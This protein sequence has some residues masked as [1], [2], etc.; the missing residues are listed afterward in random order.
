MF[1][2]CDCHGEFDGAATQP[3]VDGSATVQ[4]VPCHA[5]AADAAVERE[6]VE[7]VFALGGGE[8]ADEP[9][10]PWVAS[11]ATEADI[12][13]SARTGIQP[14]L[15][16]RWTFRYHYDGVPEY[17]DGDFADRHGFGVDYCT[18]VRDCMFGELPEVLHDRGSTWHRVASYQS[19]GEMECP[20]GHDGVPGAIVGAEPWRAEWKGER[21]LEDPDRCPLCE[22]ERGQPHGYVYIGDGWCEVVYRCRTLS[23]SECDADV[24]DAAGLDEAPEDFLC[25]DCGGEA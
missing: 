10:E 1:T 9:W 17:A 8:L 11:D 2:C 6:C 18:V 23:C 20:R 3:N 21:P 14:K 25:A 16:E 22:E 12:A 24:D 15:S 4:C 13:W 7:A 19:S 5:A